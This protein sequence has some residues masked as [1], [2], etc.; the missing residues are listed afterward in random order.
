ML[1][2]PPTVISV[3]SSA[4]RSFSKTPRAHIHLLAGMGIEGDSH[5]GVCVKHRSRVAIDPTQPNLRQVSLLHSEVFDEVAALGFVLQ[6]GDIGE[7]I[8]TEGVDLLS[9]PRGTCLHIGATAVVELTGLRNPCKQIDT[10]QKGLLKAFVGRDANGGIVLK[11]G[12][13]SVVRVGGEVCVGNSIAVV[14]P[15]GECM[16]M[17][18]V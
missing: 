12:V 1:T 16:P 15:D 5:A 14:L 11:A 13:M 10:F 18:R 8:T 6:P 17:E 4:T 3:A 2:K 7:N 9:L